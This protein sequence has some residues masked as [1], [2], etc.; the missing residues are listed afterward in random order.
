MHEACALKFGEFVLKSGRVSPYFFNLG[1]TMR[2]AKTLVAVGELYAET[3]LERD[4]VNENELLFG[5]AYKG[6]PLVAAVG[7][8]L[9]R[10]GVD[11]DICFNRKERKEHGEGGEIYGASMAGR[12]IIMLDDVIST[13]R[14]IDLARELIERQQGQFKAVLVALNRGESSFRTEDHDPY[15]SYAPNDELPVHSIASFDDVVT[16]ASKLGS[17]SK[18][19]LQEMIT[20]RDQFVAA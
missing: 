7:V 9:H 2:N 14:Q 20:Y 19:L 8:A 1:E 12:E 5:P 3:I 16:F 15:L 18:E 11:V 10:Q 4:L 6:I 13:G 17:Y